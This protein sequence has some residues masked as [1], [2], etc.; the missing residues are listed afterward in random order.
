MQ[1]MESFDKLT[2]F[3]FKSKTWYLY[4][5]MCTITSQIDCKISKI[6]KNLKR[7]LKIQVQVFISNQK[8]P[9]LG[10]K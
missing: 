1:G 3:G 6:L 4:G 8:F 10:C 7:F 5:K 9:S 2:R